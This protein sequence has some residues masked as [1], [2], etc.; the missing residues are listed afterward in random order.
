VSNI[1]KFLAGSALLII[2]L[3]LIFLLGE[4]FLQYVL[5]GMGAIICLYLSFALGNWSSLIKY[6]LI[7]AGWI[8]FVLSLAISTISTVNLPLTLS[9]LA[10]YGLSYLTFITIL[11]LPKK[12]KSIW[13]IFT[14]LLAIFIVTLISIFFQLFPEM[15]KSLPTMN[16][17]YST[18]GHNHL[19][20]ILL[21][22]IPMSWWF[23]INKKHELSEVFPNIFFQ[24][25]PFF[26]SIVL[27][28][29]FGRIAILLGLFEFL[30]IKFLLNKQKV[31]PTKIIKNE[32]RLLQILFFSILIIKIIFSVV[33]IFNPG[34]ICPIQEKEKQLCKSISN[35]RRPLYWDQAWKVIKE[36]PPIG[37][38]PGTFSVSGAK[39]SQAPLY[40]TSFAH[41]AFLENYSTLGIIGGSIFI[42]LMFNMLFKVSRAKEIKIN[43]KEELINGSNSWQFFSLISL[44]A[45]YV[46]VLFDFD[47]NFSGIFIL[48]LILIAT[49]LRETTINKDLNFL[50]KRKSEKIAKATK[51]IFVFISF[52][53]ITLSGTY[54]VVEFKIKQQKTNE[55]FEFFPYFHWHRKIFET[56]LSSENYPKLLSIYKNYPEHYIFLISKEIDPNKTALLKKRLGELSPWDKIKENNIEYYLNENQ[57]DLAQQELE[58]IHELYQKSLKTSDDWIFSYSDIKRLSQQ[59]LRFADKIWLQNPLLA[60]DFY[61][62]AQKIDSW[63]WQENSL[64]ILNDKF[65][66]Y[67]QQ[68]LEF[69]RNFPNEK[70]DYLGTNRNTYAK[71]YLLALNEFLKSQENPQ[72]IHND[73]NNILN[74]ANWLSVYAW[75]DLNEI[76]QLKITQTL[77]TNKINEVSSLISEWKKTSETIQKYNKDLSWDYKLK[78]NLVKKLQKKATELLNNNKAENLTDEIRSQVMDLVSLMNQVLPENYWVIVQPGNLYTYFGQIETAKKAFQYCLDNYYDPGKHVDCENGL[79]NL[80]QE[81]P[82]KNR[83]FEV[84][85]T[86]LSQ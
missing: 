26:F 43:S 44:C 16:L 75:A 65:D 9:Y 56:E 66:Q 46:D 33:E 54:L 15:A 79:L 27:L 35:E 52:C 72:N 42:F 64:G 86:I 53:L 8:L 51:N 45:I 3:L 50:N 17:I 58:T 82:N 36:Y 14:T 67:F 6:P 25:V 55:A 22:I 2:Y 41:N 11:V 13:V 57:Y 60:A 38:G 12:I 32:L 37:S 61:T 84:S 4:S 29:S 85:K 59:T 78:I 69:M 71:K 10:F 49:M 77:Q 40:R 19:A 18:F 81:I 30:I 39:Y 21:L 34:Y 68:R 62:K 47:W 73:L 31:S 1:L 74:M 83:Y 5:F 76:Y 24:I 20:A 48:T 23:A 80:N 63:T 28:F 70:Y 7:L